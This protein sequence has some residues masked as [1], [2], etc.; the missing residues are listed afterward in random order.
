MELAQR[1]IHNERGRR[2][3][4]KKKKKKERAQKQIKVQRI[5]FNFAS[6]FVNV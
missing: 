6:I 1:Q 4:K 5:G 2:G 3:D